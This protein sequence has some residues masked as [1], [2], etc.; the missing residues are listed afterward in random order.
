[1]APR[2]F[3]SLWSHICIYSIYMS[4]NY[5]MTISDDYREH[6]PTKNYVIKTLNDMKKLAREEGFEPSIPVLETGALGQLSYTPIND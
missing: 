4:P 2:A 3:K 1:M 6:N 5:N